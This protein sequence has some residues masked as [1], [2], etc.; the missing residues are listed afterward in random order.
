[1]AYSFKKTSQAVIQAV[2]ESTAGVDPNAGYT[3]MLVN[4]GASK[5]KESTQIERD[6]LDKEFGSFGSGITGSLWKASI[7]MEAKALGR[8][9]AEAIV[10]PEWL[11]PFLA[12]ATVMTDGYVLN[13]TASVPEFEVGETVSV[14]GS[15]IGVVVDKTASV[16]Y[17]R[18]TG[19][20]VPAAADSL[21]GND[22][23]ASATIDSVTT[24]KALEPT[25]DESLIKTMALRFNQS[26]IEKQAT[27]VRGNAV[28]T[29]TAKALPKIAFDLQGIYN[30]PSDKDMPDVTTSGVKPVP[31][32]N[33]SLTFGDLDTAKVAFSEF[34]LDLGNDVQAPDDAQ[35][36]N[37]IAAIQIQESMPKLKLTISQPLL[38]EYNPYYEHENQ[39][40]RNF[41]VTY[42]SANKFIRV[43][44]QKAQISTFSETDKNG[45]NHYSLDLSCN[46]GGKTPKWGVMLF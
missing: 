26:K 14:L 4:K 45:I 21:D 29:G 15:D 5:S 17:V 1:M 28:L 43:F 46:K 34:S 27:Y 37:S 31:F 32:Q 22:S 3:A 6:V 8:D 36:A 38:S 9:E 12:C 41:A 7:E 33:V 19:A 44:V 39:V 30:D 24:G 18:K 20:T 16:L 2:L 42:G 10:D 23:G 25:S 35:K 11:I 13:L 40:E